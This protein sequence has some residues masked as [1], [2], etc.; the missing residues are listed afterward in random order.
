MLRSSRISERLKAQ[1]QLLVILAFIGSLASANRAFGL[2]GTLN[3]PSIS[4]SAASGRNG[5]DWL[6]VLSNKKYKFVVGDFIN[7]NTNLYYSGDTASLNSF[8]KDLAAVD[9]TL[10]QI[11]FSKESMTAAS[12]FGGDGAPSGPCQWKIFHSGFGLEV[13]DVTIFLGDGKI[14]ISQLNLPA[15]QNTNIKTDPKSA[16]AAKKP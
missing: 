12:A 11:T 9:G 14:D 3:S 8:L 16:P 2:G 15:I 13:F 10:I 5:A 6:A 7:W 4:V 1:S